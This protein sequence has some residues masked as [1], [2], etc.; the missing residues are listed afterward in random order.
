M[1]QTISVSPVSLKSLKEP[2]ALQLFV[3]DQPPPSIQATT[4]RLCYAE[5][6]YPDL[7]E[8]LE[9]RKIKHSTIKIYE[10]V[11]EH[12]ER[13]MPAETEVSTID[14]NMIRTFRSKLLKETLKRAR[15]GKKAHRS[16]ATVNKLM[17]HL[18]PLIIKLW[19]PDRHN[20]G[21]L[22]L[23]EYFEFPQ[24][25]SEDKYLP[26]TY[27][28]KDLSRLY[29]NAAA[30]RPTTLRRYSPLHEPDLWRLAFTL[31]FAAGPRTWDLFGLTW[32]DIGWTDFRYG[33]IR[34]RATKTQKMQRIPL[35]KEARYHL[36]LVKEKNFD[37]VHVF[38][39]FKPNKTFYQTWN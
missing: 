5:K 38:P 32:D 11:I 37:P 20:P 24:A 2:P 28:L 23:V 39:R 6:I 13:L 19:P 30:C 27:S 34:F 18:K 31:G 21:G 16:P 15:T 29:R 3:I 1:T 36:D 8:R 22:G 25:L 26:F 35:S 33:S 4:L 10:E 14:R 17:R 7:Q 12:W 9:D